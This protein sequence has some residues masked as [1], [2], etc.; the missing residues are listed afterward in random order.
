M[1]LN[2]SSIVFVL[3]CFSIDPSYIHYISSKTHANPGILPAGKEFYILDIGLTILFKWN[4]HRILKASKMHGPLG[5]YSNCFNF[6]TKAMY[7]SHI[8]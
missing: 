8:Y 2:Y 1:Y 3:F 6:L 5:T 7:S 4:V